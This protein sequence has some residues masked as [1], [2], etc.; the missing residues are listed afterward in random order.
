[1]KTT[2][3]LEKE[4]FNFTSTEV[5]RFR[6]LVKTLEEIIENPVITLAALRNIVN[7]SRE[8]EVTRDYLTTRLIDLVKQGNL[9]D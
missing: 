2:T 7:M 1:M 8:L 5:E 9:I 3:E 4:F 6:F